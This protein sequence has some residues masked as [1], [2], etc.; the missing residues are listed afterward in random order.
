MIDLNLEGRK[1]FNVL[2]LQTGMSLK[3]QQL[4]DREQQFILKQLKSMELNKDL[5]FIG[6]CNDDNNG[7][8]M[9][10]I[11]Q[12]GGMVYGNDMCQPHQVE[13]LFESV[14]KQIAFRSMQNYS[15]SSN[16]N[17]WISCNMNALDSM[18][19]GSKTRSGMDKEDDGVSLEFLG[20]F[21]KQFATDSVGLD[22][23]DV[24]FE[25]TSEIS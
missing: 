10:H 13:E 24:N 16:H 18:E 4:Y 19:F 7:D 23:S 2:E 6:A 9:N 25:V 8:S 11:L 14:Q 15:K 21:M 22:L 17:F 12:Q 5:I 3:N 20:E 1:H